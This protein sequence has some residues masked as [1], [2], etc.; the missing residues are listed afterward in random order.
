[1]IRRHYLALFFGTLSALALNASARA[2]D[3]PDHPVTIIV[4]FGPGG[5]TDTMARLAAQDLTNKFGQI[6]L[7]FFVVF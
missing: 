3:W 1:M 6:V 4:P 5:N 2:G 7:Q